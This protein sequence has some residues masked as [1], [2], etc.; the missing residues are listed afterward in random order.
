MD[1]GVGEEVEAGDPVD[2]VQEAAV[3]ST[4][5]RMRQKYDSAMLIAFDGEDQVHTDIFS[6]PSDPEIMWCVDGLGSGKYRIRPLDQQTKYLDAFEG[7][8]D[9]NVVLRDYQGNDSQIW[10]LSTGPNGTYRVRQ[11]S[12]LRYLDAYTSNANRRA[13]TRPSQSN[14]TQLWR[15]ENACD[16]CVAP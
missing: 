2:Q 4:C 13:V 3:S 9:S 14:D 15:L 7:C 8:C 10:N 11:A 16:A 1:P 5:V 6:A 12:S